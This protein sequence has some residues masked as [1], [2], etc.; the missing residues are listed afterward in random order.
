MT[1]GYVEGKAYDEATWFQRFTVDP[2]ETFEFGSLVRLSDDMTVSAV[3]AAGG[4]VTFF[5]T[6]ADAPIG[7]CMSSKT[8]NYLSPYGDH[9]VD[10]RMF[11]K[12]QRQVTLTVPGGQQLLAKK[13]K[14]AKAD[15]ETVDDLDD[16]APG[17]T[18]KESKK[19]TEPMKAVKN[20]PAGIAAGDLITLATGVKALAL[21]SGDP[22]DTIQVLVP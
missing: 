12:F 4:E 10:V 15:K 17:T 16:L 2:A 5:D 20:A 13:S 9:A 1:T 21:T 18:T 7:V 22:G 11:G 14:E 3:K 8:A 19:A 6:G